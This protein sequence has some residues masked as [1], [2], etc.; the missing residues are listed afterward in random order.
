[1]LSTRA[2]TADGNGDVPAGRY[3]VLRVMD[4]GCG[5]DE[6]TRTRAFEP[7]FTTKPAGRGTGLGLSTVLEIVRGAGGHLRVWSEVGGGTEFRIYLPPAVAAPTDPLPDLSS[8]YRIRGSEVVLV[9]DDDTGVRAVMCLALRARGYTVLEAGGVAEA[10]AAAEE[11]PEPIHLA[12][13]DVPA[14]TRTALADE[15]RSAHADLR[16]LLVSGSTDQVPAAGER[17][18]DFLAKP[19]TPTGLATKVREILDR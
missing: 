2:E 6:A 10:R 3:A 14:P 11:H 15:L 1:V 19:F 5:M 12:V 7:F 17:E 9:V 8:E 4:T 18:A 13:I 16:V